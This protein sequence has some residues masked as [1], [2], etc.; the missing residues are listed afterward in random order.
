VSPTRRLIGLLAGHRRW[1]LAGA[2]LG[3]LAIG[4]N[5]ALMA[6]S[7]YLISKAALVTNVADIA[8]T[9]TAVRVLA[10]G[11][12]AFRYLERYVTHRV[13]FDVLADLRVWFFASVEPLAPAGLATHRR[14]DLLGRIVADIDTLEDF[15]V[16]VVSPPI[17]A[18]LVTAFAAGILGLFEPILGVVLVAFVAFAGIVLPVV[19]RRLS[20]TAARTLIETRAELRASVVDELAGMADL[21]AL[22][23][24]SWHRDRT[25]A[26]GAAT[27]DV[28]SELA[29]VRAWA[30]A[31]ATVVAGL[32][33]VTILGI[34]AGLVENGRL[35]GVWLAA[36]PLAALA[37]FEAMGPLAQAFA[38]QDANEAAAERLFALTDAAPVA[39]D[40]ARPALLPTQSRAPSLT[41]R[42]VRFRYAADEPLVLDGCTLEVPAG[43]SLA[44]L[45]PSGSGKT[46][47]VNLLA[48]FWAPDAGDV[49]VGGTSVR[50]LRAEDVRSLLAVVEQDV[51][52][53]DATIRDNLAV[54]DADVTDER[55]EAAC[56][57]AG[58]HDAIA[59]MPAGYETWIGEGGLLLSAGER[60][61]LAIA[62]ALIKDAPIVVLDEATANLDVATERALLASLRTHLAGK[63]VLAI[64]HR[65]AVAAAMDRTVRLDAGRAIEDPTPVAEPVLA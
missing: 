58:I 28:L 63:T 24:T 60:Q 36:L 30:G 61:R 62:R 13:T 22:D 32:A 26:L 42:D 1:V 50:D 59:T 37:T 10:I 48:R 31:L 57:L 53:F 23:R 51:H 25:L 49:C 65:E 5:V 39:T 12:A 34:G 16:R 45:G 3:F 54:A 18:A 20:R 43:T 21:A 44:I 15:Y 11:R 14:G 29:R 47:L 19:A 46:T 52:L 38:L 35:D 64:T 8:L 9:I 27:D 33:A 2:L 7:A 55:I 41:F 4:A 40:P 17:V 6:T 56:R